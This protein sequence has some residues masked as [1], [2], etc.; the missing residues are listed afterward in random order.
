MVEAI[1]RA[2]IPVMGH[3]GLTP[4]SLH[5]FG[6]YRVQGRTAEAAALLRRDA[7]LL[8]DAGCFALVLEAIP[9]ALAAEITA[10]LHIP[11]IGIGAGPGC[12]GQV[13]VLHDLLGLYTEFVPKFVQRYA[14]LGGVVRTALEAFVRDVRSGRFPGQE[15]SYRG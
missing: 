6:G 8:Q 14:E 11:T 7:R 2:D 4:Q 3:L 5:R 12:D 15:H 13:L 10:S 1:V 9:A